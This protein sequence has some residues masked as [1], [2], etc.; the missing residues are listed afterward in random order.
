VVPGWFRVLDSGEVEAYK[1][2]QREL[3]RWLDQIVGRFRPRDREAITREVNRTLATAL[4]HAG[5][6]LE[7]GRLRY[8][9]GL[10]GVQAVRAFGVALILDEKRG[11]TGRLR[12]CPACGKF[13][14]D[15]NLKGR[16]REVCDSAKCKRKFEALRVQ[17]WRTRRASGR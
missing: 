17:R 8:Y 9:F 4:D 10:T 14:L 7:N 15:W 6:R 11:L 16:P 3:K 2:D 5:V 1:G 13:R 12:E